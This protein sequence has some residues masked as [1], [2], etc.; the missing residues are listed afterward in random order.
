PVLEGKIISAR[1]LL[2]NISDFGLAHVARRLDCGFLLV[3][4]DRA[5]DHLS[6]ITDRTG[7]LPIYYTIENGN[8]VASSSFKRL[9]DS[10]SAR[11][12]ASLD[13]CALAEFLHFRRVFGTRTYD[14]AIS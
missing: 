4:H 12:N 8:F 3:F 14:S 5:A 7:S 2:Q 10:S 9:F 6:I 13:I 1:N 11:G